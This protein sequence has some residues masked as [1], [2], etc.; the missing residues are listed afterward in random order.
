MVFQMWL[1]S[2][3]SRDNLI[4]GGLVIFLEVSEI[5]N[6]IIYKFS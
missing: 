4:R 2:A 3:Y 1:Q 5:Y 6:F